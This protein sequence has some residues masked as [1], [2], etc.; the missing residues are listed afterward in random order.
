MAVGFSVV[1]C[2]GHVVQA[3]VL[4]RGRCGVGQAVGLV[5]EAVGG[6]EA[7]T[8]TY[9]AGPLAGVL[10]VKRVSLKA[11]FFGSRWEKKLFRVRNKTNEFCWQVIIFDF[12]RKQ[13]LL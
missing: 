13:H 5:G 6:T 2:D 9:G 1:V 12:D 10:G 11:V 4:R 7:L 3:V 8:R